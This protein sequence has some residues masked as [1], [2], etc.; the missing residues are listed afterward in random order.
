MAKRI[1]VDG[2]GAGYSHANESPN[3][4]RNGIATATQ[5]L[6]VHPLDGWDGPR[7]PARVITGNLILLSVLLIV[8]G[9]GVGYVISGSIKP[10]FGARFQVSVP[11]QNDTDAL[12]SR[13]LS[14]QVQVISG[15]AL[16]APV[17]AKAKLPLD[18]LVEH[19]T[20]T[21]QSGSSII[22]V[23]V[24]ASSKPAA[25]AIARDLSSRYLQTSPAANLE[26]T[27]YLQDQ[28]TKVLDDQRSVQTRLANP[29]NTPALTR[30]LTLQS[31]NLTSKLGALQNQLT[32]TD[33]QTLSI[34]TLSLLTPPYA[35]ADPVSPH[36]LQSLALGALGGVVIALGVLGIVAMLRRPPDSG[37]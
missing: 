27:K 23:L 17:A 21:T 24:T 10:T 30:S 19:V 34:G 20:A 1:D 31:D 13:Q 12:V 8:I 36:R 7:R 29:I 37:Q 6:P 25:V 5:S 32:V 4:N 26:V 22:D 2:S 14:N 11:I 28:I 9:A 18:T 33:T 35:L 16:L 15:R 3:G